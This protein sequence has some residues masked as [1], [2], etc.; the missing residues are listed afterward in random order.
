M[1]LGGDG[2]RSGVPRH[3]NQ[4]CETLAGRARLTLVHEANQGGFDAPGG[5]A[6]QIEIGG[7]RSS[8]HPRAL[9]RGW[10]SVSR[11]LLTCRCDVIWLHARLPAI[12][13][14][15]AL[16]SGSVRLPRE[17]RVVLSYHGLPF[18]PGHRATAAWLSLRL[19]RMLLRR[20]PPMHLVVL[21][22]GAEMRLRRAMGPQVLARHR[23]HVLPN[24][25]N[26]GVLPRPMPGRAERH[27]VITGRAGHQKNY[28]LAA[29]LMD[30]LPDHYVLT[31]CGMGTQD[32]A[33][34]MRIRRMVRPDTRPRI[35]FA[36]PVADVRQILAQADC[37][38]LTSR[39]EGLPIGA[40][41]AFEAGLP[42]VLTPFEAAVDL[43]AA[44][45]RAICLPLRDLPRDAVRIARLIEDYRLNREAQSEIIRRAWQRAY[46]Y[47]LWQGRVRGLM[48]E[49]LAD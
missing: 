19:E 22:R 17:T 25:S 24:T 20:C 44:H 33:F 11:V 29:R 5:E 26:L 10:R 42:L 14:R 4:L 31:L 49:I 40:I 18:G 6:R 13:A 28:P 23:L 32:P 48:Q 3:L 36:G 27:L 9:W 47:E 7:L 37:Y 8:L 46:P 12:L 30:H 1:L 2:G 16:V 45:P 43:V 41:E 35:R 38:L 15:L 39:Y 34:Q 21:G